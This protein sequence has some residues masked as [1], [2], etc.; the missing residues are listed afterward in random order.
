MS[1]Q[2]KVRL[3]VRA[4]WRSI[5]R[6]I[7][8]GRERESAVRGN[9]HWIRRESARS[10]CMRQP[11]RQGPR[12]GLEGGTGSQEPRYSTRTKLKTTKLQRRRVPN[13]GAWQFVA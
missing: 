2:H 9:R 10:F 11:Q 3:A 7:E 6:K 12:V 1:A 8:R 4:S 13:P 5:G